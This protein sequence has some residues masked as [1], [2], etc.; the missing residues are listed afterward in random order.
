MLHPRS[1][2]TARIPLQA[3]SLYSLSWARLSQLRSAGIVL[4]LNDSLCGTPN[5]AVH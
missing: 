3:L 5:V 4:R 1:C 2:V